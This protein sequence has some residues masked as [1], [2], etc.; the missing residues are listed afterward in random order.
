MKPKISAGIN[1]ESRDN[2]DRVAAEGLSYISIA[3]AILGFFFTWLQFRDI[4]IAE[5]VQK[6][7]GSLCQAAFLARTCAH[8]LRCAAAILRR[9]E[10][11]IVRLPGF[12][13]CAIGTTFCLLLTFAQR[14]LC[15]AEIFFRAEADRLRRGS[16]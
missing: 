13:A 10:G 5:L 8:L 6:T 3:A 2:I 16:V 9:A 15:A 12:E 11:D 1:V 4:P 7:N 14:A